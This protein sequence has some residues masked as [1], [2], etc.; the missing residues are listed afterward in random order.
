MSQSAWPEEIILVEDCSGDSGQTLALLEAIK[1]ESRGE[2]PIRILPL[3]ENLG[4][5]EARNAG[6]AVASQDFI[7]F[8]DADDT[9]HPRKLEFQLGWMLAHPHCVLTC[10]DTQVCTY[11]GPPPLLNTELHVQVVLWRRMLFINDI[12][13]R[14]VVLKRQ[15][16][17]RFPDGVRYAEDYALWMRILLEGGSA[18]RLKLP[19]ACSYKE[20]F[21]DGGLSAHLLEM[22]RSVLLCL[23]MLFRDS[24]I[25]RRL[26][27]VAFLFE[28]LKYWRRILVI[29]A[30]RVT[31][32]AATMFSLPPS[33]I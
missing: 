24:L 4:A 27:L 21:G 1:S 16:I 17:H 10:H 33:V 19:L 8:L 25:S 28:V 12:A 7:A 6:W 3:H 26:Y 18:M 32:L 22:H 29:G 11:E 2:T 31:R 20:E 23:D 9:W 30:K 15:I 5:G 13:T 14:T